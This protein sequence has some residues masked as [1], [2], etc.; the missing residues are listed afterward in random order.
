MANTPFVDPLLTPDEPVIHQGFRWRFI[1]NTVEARP[2]AETFHEYLLDV[3]HRTLGAEWCQR[4]TRQQ[5]RDRH[6]VVRWFE[7]FFEFRRRM[8][9]NENRVPGGWSAVP[10][11]EITALL[12]LAYDVYSL[13][14]VDQL[15][16]RQL[17]RIRNRNEFQGVRY[18]LSVAAIFAR[19]G[20]DVRWVRERHGERTCDLEATHR[21]TRQ[22]VAIEAK[23]RRKRG[24]LH[25]AGAFEPAASFRADVGGLLESALGQAPDETPFIVCIDLNVRPTPKI[26]IN[27]KPWRPDAFAMMDRYGEPSASAPDPFNAVVLT[28]FSPHYL[29]VQPAP[30]GGTEFLA[31]ISRHPRHGLAGA[32]GDHLLDAVQRYGMVPIDE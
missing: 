13:L 4:E 5:S 9:T 23:S 27:D 19:A 12:A 22:V 17:R 18:E 32:A 26:P 25:E 30:D 28:N 31:I 24:V 29:G 1:K 2:Q 6:V 3:L 14:R 7:A 16:K 10:T 21:H 20:F 11:G 8:A 15:P